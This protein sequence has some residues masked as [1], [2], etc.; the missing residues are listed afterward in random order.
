MSAIP[1]MPFFQ[2]IKRKNVSADVQ[3]S[4]MAFGGR[5][6]GTSDAVDDTLAMGNGTVKHRHSLNPMF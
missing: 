6:N 3:F 5:R 1:E 4:R 2:G